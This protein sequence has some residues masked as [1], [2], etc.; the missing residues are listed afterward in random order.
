MK[1]INLFTTLTALTIAFSACEQ[2]NPTPI[3]SLT[4]QEKADLIFMLEEEK[5]ARDSYL[6]LSE[7]WSEPQFANIASSEQKHMDAITDLCNTYQV[8]F[9]IL[10][11]GVFENAELQELY[12]DLVAQGEISAIEALKVGATIEDVDIV[13]LEERAT[14]TSRADIQATYESL[15]CGSRNH[16]RAFVKGLDNYNETY[17][18]Q[19]LSQEAF[20]AIIAGSH[21][22]CDL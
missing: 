11:Q 13:D 14:Q 10:D 16:L 15:T 3:D 2:N 7:L 8:E 1:T 21:E 19:F 12:N 4:D 20:D 17:T 5:L 6:H 18:P 22:D 9:T